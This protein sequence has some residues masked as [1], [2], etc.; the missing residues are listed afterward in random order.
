LV[1]CWAEDLATPPSLGRELAE[2][3]PNGRFELIPEAAHL[4]SIEQPEVLATV[5]RQFLSEQ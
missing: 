3:L 5:I 4:P 2:L 1:L